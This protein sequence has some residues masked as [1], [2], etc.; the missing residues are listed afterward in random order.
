MS[1]LS[2]Q[3]PFIR[4]RGRSFMALVLMPE[5]PTD[6]WL[7]TLDD[8]RRRAPS[9]FEARPVIVDASTMPD[10]GAELTALVEALQARDIRIIGVEGANPSWTDSATWGRTPLLSQSR[11][12][13]A[14]EIAD[15]PPEP[16][17]AAPA[18]PPEPPSLLVDRPVRSGQT[19]LFER[20]DV[21]VL[22][23]VASG[24]EVIAGGSIHV[25]GALRGRAIAGMAGDPAARIFCTRLDAE[26]LAIDGIYKT[27][28]DISPNL[29]GR[30]VQARLDGDAIILSALG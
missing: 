14:L 11:A 8:Q 17:P 7:A 24:A 16:S 25:Y 1:D 5:R 21:T 20:G 2:P 10:A 18:A 9:F 19:I 28:E 22:G 6:D 29:R 23:S 27:A 30:P 26:L 3:R 12:D 15:D 13:R 4:V